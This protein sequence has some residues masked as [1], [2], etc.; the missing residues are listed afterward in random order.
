MSTRRGE[1]TGLLVQL[2]EGNREV[3]SKLVPLVYN[4]L[5]R[6]ADHYMRRERSNHTLQATALVNEAYL[7][8]VQQRSVNWQTRAHFFGLAAQLMRRILTDHARRYLRQKRPGAHEVVPFEEAAVFSPNRSE[9]LLRLDVSLER[10]T[11]RD[12]RQ[13]KIVELRFFGGLTVEETAGLLGISSKTVKREW[14]FA[15]AW[16]HGDMK[17]NHGNLAGEMG[18]R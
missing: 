12:P 6:L 11:E 14:S 5:H 8:L 9:E 16:L 15:K 4:E 10:L 18:Y 13:G 17:L 1:I 2:T 7:K 3:A